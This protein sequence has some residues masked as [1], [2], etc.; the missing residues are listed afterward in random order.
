VWN[1]SPKLEP[2]RASFFD[3][4]SIA[5]TRVTKLPDFVFFNH[6]V[7]VAKGVGCVECH[8]RVDRMAV[9][10]QVAPLAMTWCLD[11]HRNPAP[12]QRPVEAVTDMAWT[13]KE[14]VASAIPAAHPRTEC[15]TCHR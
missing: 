6:S 14:A 9:V 3:D 4:R 15:T 10:E 7:H 1:D 2:V 8:G 12:R 11:C 5:W 13:P